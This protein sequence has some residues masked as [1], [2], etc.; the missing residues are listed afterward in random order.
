[1]ASRGRLGRRYLRLRW[2][3]FL[4]WWG[5]CGCF[6]LGCGCLGLWCG[7]FGLGCRGLPLWWGCRRL[8]WGGQRLLCSRRGCRDRRRDR[9]HRRRRDL[10]RLGRNNLPHGG[11][12]DPCDEHRAV[13]ARLRTL[14]SRPRR[15]WQ[16]CRTHRGR[17]GGYQGRDHRTFGTHSPATHS[18]CLRCGHASIG[19]SRRA[20][21][22]AVCTKARW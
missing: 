20:S 17:G 18:H 8:S 2:G 16:L 10:G 9:L 6:G 11:W 22:L 3:C 4:L 12:P 14:R 15:Q 1:M 7:C 19:P 21:H 13:R 5:R